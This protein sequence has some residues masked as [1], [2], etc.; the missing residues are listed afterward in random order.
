MLDGE[1][2]VLTPHPEVFTHA[3]PLNSHPREHQNMSLYVL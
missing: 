2:E 3:L 1:E